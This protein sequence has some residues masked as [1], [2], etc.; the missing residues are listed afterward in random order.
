[1]EVVEEELMG[2][3]ELLEV[4]EEELMEVLMEVVVLL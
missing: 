1:L 2:V 3:D 4:V